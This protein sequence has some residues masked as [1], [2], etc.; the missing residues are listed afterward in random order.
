MTPNRRIFLN[1]VATYG[2]S[3][4]ALIIGLFCGRWAL[5][6]LGEVD[7]GLMGVVGGLTAFVTFINTLMAMGVGRFYAISVGLESKTPQLGLERC[8][9]WFT[10]AIA[11]HMVLPIVLIIIGYPIGVW[12]VHNFLVIPSER[13]N[14]CLWVW[15]FACISSLVSMMSVPF[16]AMYS[17]KQEIAELTI[18]SFV[19]TTLN[20]C[21]LFYAIRHSG[22]WLFRYTLWGCLLSI[23]PNIIISIRSFCKYQECRVRRHYFYCWGKIKE[24]LS[25]CGWIIIGMLADVFRVQGSNI[26]VNKVFGPRVNASMAISTTVSTNCTT[27]A[28]SMCGAFWPAIMNLYGAGNIN[29]ARQ[30]AFRVCKFSMFLIAIFALPLSLEINEVMLLWLKKPPQYVSGLCICL[31]GML[32]AD[33]MTEGHVIM[34]NARGKMAIYQL[35]VGGVALLAIPLALVFLAFKNIVYSVG[36]ALVVT[37]FLQSIARVIFARYLVQMSVRTWFF[38]I[39]FPFSAMMLISYVAGLLPK[40]FIPASLGRVFL[41]S[42]FVDVV[43][44][45]GCWLCLFERDEKTWCVGRIKQIIHWRSE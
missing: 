26:L 40:C 25:Y 2:R 7:Y 8:R 11:V 32:M 42:F 12:A 15:R 4:Y 45:L 41:T 27:L 37:R 29:E 10:T 5:M 17:A 21:F 19:T 9:E 44:L 33:K 30:M 39:V 6:A 34:V 36:V 24:M 43:L 28:G 14:A 22:D 31:L 13:I 38:K 16:A 1:I 20:I 3:L 23:I 18:Y 35:V